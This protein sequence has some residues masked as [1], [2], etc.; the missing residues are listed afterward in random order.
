MRINFC[1]NNTNK[2]YCYYEWP[3]IALGDTIFKERQ[4]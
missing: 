1:I 4:R 2:K 3:F